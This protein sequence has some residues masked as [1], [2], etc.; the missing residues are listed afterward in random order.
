MCELFAIEWNLRVTDGLTTRYGPGPR[1]DTTLFKLVKT[2][3]SASLM[4]LISDMRPS[5]CWCARVS[6]MGLAGVDCWGVTTMVC[7]GLLDLGRS[8]VDPGL[9]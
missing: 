1:P 4:L 5:S 3:S 8:K 9:S 7:R 2:S 6:S